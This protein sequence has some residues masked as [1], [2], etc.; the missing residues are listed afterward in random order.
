VFLPLGGI[1]VLFIS[2]RRSG[3][4]PFACSACGRVV[5]G[6][7]DLGAE[8]GGLCSPCYQALYQRENI[9]RERRH[10]QIRK[11]ARYQSRRSRRLLMLNFVMP[12]LGFSLLDEKPQGMF[13]LFGFFF[14]LLAALFWG[15]MLPVPMTVWETGGHALRILS[16]VVVI[17]F[18]WFVQRMFFAKI[19]ARR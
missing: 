9:P 17:F 18:Y 11:M 4:E 12:G 2:R 16:F 15:A 3:Q 5:C 19:R 7:C 8:V 10:E 1:Y 6:K 13:I 14:L